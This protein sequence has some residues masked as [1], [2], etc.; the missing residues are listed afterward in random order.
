MKYILCLTLVIFSAC[1]SKKIAEPPV[2]IKPSAK[3]LSLWEAKAQIKDIKNNKSHQV[4]LDFIAHWPDAMRVDV[5][6]PMGVALASLMVKKNEIQYAL[7]RQ[8]AFYEGRASDT[9]LRSIFRLDLDARHLLNICFDKPILQ[10]NWKCENDASGL[11]ATCL[12]HDGLQI[13]WT[14]RDGLKKRVTIANPEFE[15]QVVFKSYSTKVLNDNVEEN[16][17]KNP[18][19]INPPEDF[20]RYKIL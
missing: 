7:F 13:R 1:V 6:G 14:D 20:K 2:S 19:R 17:E 11:V 4:G 9:A 5:S 10:K 15:V 18:F 3:N 8:K 12:R 16:I